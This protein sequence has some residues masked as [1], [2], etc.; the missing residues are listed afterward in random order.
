M[1]WKEKNWG[2]SVQTKLT[3][4][5]EGHNTVRNIGKWLCVVCGKGTGCNLIRCTKCIKWAQNRCRTKGSLTN[6]SISFVCRLCLGRHQR[7]IK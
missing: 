1:V 2:K 5:W 7:V 6:A 4:G 3:V